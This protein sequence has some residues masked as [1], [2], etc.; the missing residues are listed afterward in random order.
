MKKNSQKFTF[1]IVYTNK[2]RV[3]QIKYKGKKHPIKSKVKWLNTQH[4][5]TSQLFLLTTISVGKFV[6]S[7]YYR[8]KSLYRK[9]YEM[10]IIVLVFPLVFLN[11]KISIWARFFF[12]IWIRIR[13][14]STWIRTPAHQFETA[15]TLQA[16][17]SVRMSR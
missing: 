17:L 6:S 1:S 11:G 13:V 5:K 16:Y 7:Q 14:S 12:K 15:V 2:N 9:F 10:Q 4:F 3:D 8:N